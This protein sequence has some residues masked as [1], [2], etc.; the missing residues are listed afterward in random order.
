M[1]YLASQSPRRKELL[2]LAGLQFTVLVSGCDEQVPAGLSP[3][4]TVQHLAVQKGEAVAALCQKDDVI[5]AADTV[6]VIDGKIL[7]KPKTEAEAF[8]MLRMLSD[9]THAVL[10]GVCIIGQEQK[11]T[12]VSETQVTFYALSDAEINAYIATGDPF[13]KAGGYGIQSKGVV[14]VEKIN[15]D[16]SN[17]VGLPLAACVR[18]LR[19][20][21]IQ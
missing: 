11:Q 12:F 5:L 8:A 15:G 19:D 17:V 2:T 10:T 9:R 14:L 3:A 7:G 13:D 16:Y 21:G 4:E 20:F 18:V 1:L 6:V